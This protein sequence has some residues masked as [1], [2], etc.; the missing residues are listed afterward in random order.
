[1]MVIILIIGIIIITAC[2]RDGS[3]VFSIVT[4]FF[5]FFSINTITYESLHSAW[6]NFAWTCIL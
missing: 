1:M 5:I 4:K 3:I 2:G 6:W